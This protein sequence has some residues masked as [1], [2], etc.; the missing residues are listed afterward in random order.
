MKRKHSKWSGEA[1]A[2]A[3]YE[4]GHMV[5]NTPASVV[6][7]FYTALA[8]SDATTIGALLDEH[9]ASDVVL[10]LPPGLPYAGALSGSSAVKSMFVAAATAPPVV[11][12]VAPTVESLAGTDTVVFAE[13]RFTWAG[14]GGTGEG[15][16]SLATEKWA[17]TDGKISAIV[18]YYWDPTACPA[19]ARSARNR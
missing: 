13:V 8:A 18:A 9:L 5:D 3:T 2:G 16:E 11:G 1:E 10:Q 14:A 12:P 15:G 19:P 4:W 7:R 17:F 6:A